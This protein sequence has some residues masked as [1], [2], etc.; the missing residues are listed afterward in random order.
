MMHGVINPPY[1]FTPLLADVAFCWGEQQRELMK[2]MGTPAERLVITGCQR[3]TR[4][5]S[6]SKAEARSRIGVASER[7]V[8][9]LASSPID[10]DG[11]RACAQMFCEALAQERGMAAVVRLHPSEKAAFYAREASRFPTV[12]FRESQGWPVSEALAAADVV[13]CQNSGL[14]NDALIYKCVV[15]VL[16]IAG[17][18][19]KNGKELVE[20][21]GC[22][23]VRSPEALRGTVRRTLE[24]DE[25]RQSLAAQG[26][27]FVERFCGAFG[28]EATTLAVAEIERRTRAGADSA[29]DGALEKRQGRLGREGTLEE[30]EHL[31]HKVCSA[32]V[33]RVDG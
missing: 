3:L 33:P 32:R 13:V 10:L 29:Q 2:Q 7:P 11:R 6:I 14:G 8:V 18:S 21:A 20:K 30:Q 9:L 17:E 24:D 23:L 15:V 28:E 16:D 25:Y 1:G 22:P 31:Q 27:A 5:S 26:E 19:L 12:M 4:E